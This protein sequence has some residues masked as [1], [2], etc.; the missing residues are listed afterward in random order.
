MPQNAPVKANSLMKHFSRAQNPTP[1]PET[2]ES[3]ENSELGDG[4]FDQPSK[5]SGVTPGTAPSAMSR[6]ARQ[7]VV[8]FKSSEQL[9]ITK[10]AQVNQCSDVDVVSTPS[11]SPT[12]KARSLEPQSVVVEK[13][14]KLKQ[15]EENNVIQKC[16]DDTNEK[17]YLVS[18]RPPVGENASFGP[19]SPA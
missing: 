9:N 11:G 15:K 3:E 10:D 14:S 12:K 4:A 1:T 13:P 16:T 7:R 19:G 18:L 17:H 5:A 6:V 2:K 8:D